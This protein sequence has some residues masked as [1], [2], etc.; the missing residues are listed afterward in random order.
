MNPVPVQFTHEKIEQIETIKQAIK[1]DFKSLGFEHAPEAVDDNLAIGYALSLTSE[2]ISMKN[3]V[4][5]QQNK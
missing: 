1:A 3:L 5:N 2:I 4:S